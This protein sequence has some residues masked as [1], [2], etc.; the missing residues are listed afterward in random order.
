MNSQS[1]GLA[2]REVVGSLNGGRLVVDRLTTHI[3]PELLVRPTLLSEALSKVVVDSV[4]LQSGKPLT[5]EIEFD[6]VVGQTSCVPCLLSDVYVWAVPLGRYYYRRFALGREPESTNIVTVC[7]LWNWRLGNW[8]L[9]AA[10]L[11][12][13][14]ELYRADIFDSAAS[15]RYHFWNDYV[16]VYPGN[17]FV[18][19][20]TLTHNRPANWHYEPDRAP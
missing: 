15:R 10:Y 18:R 2:T 6:R 5:Y 9:R 19:P 16:L 3:H 11:G 8:E 14:P 12:P 17:E 1:R 13:S 4:D 20:K 7:I